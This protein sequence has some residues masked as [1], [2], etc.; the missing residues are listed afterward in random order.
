MKKYLFAAL[1]AA[2]GIASAAS[3]NLLQ[4]G[5]FSIGLYGWS[6]RSKPAQKITTGADAN[7]PGGGAALCV[8]I[9]EDGGKNHG[10]LVQFRQGVKPNAQYRVSALVKSDSA[11]MA[12]VQVKL[13]K[14]KGEGTRFSTGTAKQAGEWVELSA[15]IPT[16]ADTTGI[17]VLLRWRMNAGLV[18]KRVRF[19]RV[20]LVGVSGGAESDEPPAKPAAVQPAVAAP[21]RDQYVTPKGAGVRDGTSW[22][23]ARPGTQEG[24]S[25]ALA[26]L[27]PGCALHIAGG[28]YPGSISLSL[29]KGGES[30][31]R[32]IRIVGEDRGVAGFPRPVFRG[33]WVRSKPSAGPVFLSLGPGAGFIGVENIEVRNYRS[34]LI[35]K[36]PN[37]CLRIWKVDTFDCRDAFWFEGGMVAGLPESGS[38]GI[39]MAD[40]SVVR[41]TK[42]AVRTMNGVH[43][44]KFVRCRTDAG[45][46]DFAM[47]EP[48][49]AFPCGFHLLGSYRAKDGV[50]RAD[51]HI[52]FIECEA[53]N[54]WHEPGPDKSYWN[55]DGFC[56]ESATEDIVFTR[57]TAKGNTD[58]GWDVKS[59]RPVFRE[60]SGI[61]NKRNFRVWTHK[62]ETAFFEKCLSEGSVDFG[63]RGHHVGYWLL[64]GGNAEFFNCVSRGDA[65]PISVESHDPEAVTHIDARDCTFGEADLFR[66][67]G[68]VVF[69]ENKSTQR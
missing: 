45:G 39:V 28:E 59:V 51:H 6:N 53:D 5:D 2:V 49:D 4:N 57:C 46:R 33:S 37:N 20:A 69:K 15:D 3:Q 30:L 65:R 22:D 64:G 55:A 42:K 10:Q 63:S 56:T 34:T 38:A 13:M 47:A 19:A 68:K 48:I 12:Y 14:G 17:Q 31:E 24:F 8:D 21:G 61:G 50:R 7:V 1:F 41:H 16:E 26:A 29:S 9:V 44:S 60:C 18:G 43:H 35:A 58:G 52:E 11:D 54:N 25:A 27:G 66:R 32:P 67:D 23:N 40:C 62:G 36:G